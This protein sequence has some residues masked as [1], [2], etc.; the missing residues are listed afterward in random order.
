L[1][2]FLI[3]KFKKIWQIHEQYILK[4]MLGRDNIFNIYHKQFWMLDKYWKKE[5]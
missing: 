3:E 2:C 1:F 4:W 5:L